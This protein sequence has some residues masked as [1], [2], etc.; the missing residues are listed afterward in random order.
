MSTFEFFVP[1]IPKP[2]GSKK[3]FCHSATGKVMVIDA[4]SSSRDW[5][6]TVSQFALVAFA[7]RSLLDGPLRLDC[8]FHM[9]RP[10]AHFKSNGRVKDSAPYWHTYTPDA[11]KLLR[12]VEDALTNVIWRD[13]KLIVHQ[14]VTKIYSESP[15]V[16]ISVGAAA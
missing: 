11:T 15:G 13:D 12:C 16:Q 3:A 8:E 14:T 4:C 5:K 9:P 1:G 7:G 10:A 2:A 6:T